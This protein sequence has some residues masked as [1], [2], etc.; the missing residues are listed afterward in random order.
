MSL[1]TKNEQSATISLESPRPGLFSRLPFSTLEKI[2]FWA[3]IVMS[4]AGIGGVTAL[5][6]TSGAPSADSV[7]GMVCA[8][9]IV[10]FL[11][12]RMRWAPLVTTV[13]GAY[14][15]Y[16]VATEPYALASLTDPKGPDGGFGKFAGIVI[17]LACT[18]LVVGC[19]AGA[20][21]QNYRQRD[22]QAPRLLPAALTLVAGMAIGAIF[23]G[24]LS[25]P[26]I[27]VGTTYTNGVPTVHM[28]AT[29]FDQP[30]VT[31]SKGSK[32]MLVDDTSVVHILA[33]GSWQNG[34]VQK[35]REAGAPLV[36]NLQMN[37]N[38]VAIGPFT[39]AG[40]YHIYCEVH[41][42]MNLTVIVQ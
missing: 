5:F 1:E 40:T 28:N 42:G 16:V 11:A 21:L 10:I 30:S 19:S 6:I 37:G 14:S 27:P 32:L 34:T 31:I 12:T 4:L 23:I 15:L 18:L 20:A 29:N 25:Q 39:T 24:A 2:A 33:N 35:V 8:L 17:T 41:Q 3:A 26:P 7:T 9:L 38:S 36:N 22:R 13:I